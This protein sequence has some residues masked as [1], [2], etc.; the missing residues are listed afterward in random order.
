MLKPGLS[1]GEGLEAIWPVRSWD[2]W[3]LRPDDPFVLSLEQATT[4]FNDL[5]G[6]GALEQHEGQSRPGP[7]FQRHKDEVDAFTR[8][9][10]ATFDTM[11][12]RIDTRKL[13]HSVR[14][15]DQAN[16]TDKVRL[17]IREILMNAIEHGTQNLRNGSAQARWAFGD[18]GFVFGLEQTP[19]FRDFE[20]ALKLGTYSVGR[21]EHT[22]KRGEGLTMA[23]DAI[24]PWFWVR[25]KPHSSEVLILETA[26]R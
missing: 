5:I 13:R 17:L 1:F 15:G 25:Q 20:R 21:G 6:K 4:R 18:E 10:W 2:Q 16:K 8:F 7:H 22:K 14:D 9:K 24:Y 3:D 19:P 11:D 12:K 26:G 23:A